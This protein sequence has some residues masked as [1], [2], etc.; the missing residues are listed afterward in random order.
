VVCEELVEAGLLGPLPESQAV[1]VTIVTTSN[2]KWLTIFIDFFSVVNL[3]M[4][5][6]LPE[7]AGGKQTFFAP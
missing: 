2:N 6:L 3:I 7:N 4:Q 5:M 1:S